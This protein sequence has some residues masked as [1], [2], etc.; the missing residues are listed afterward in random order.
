M[1][2]AI[3]LA[4]AA[5]LMLLACALLWSRWPAWL[6]GVLVIGVTLLYFVGNAAIHGIWG[7]PSTDALPERFLMLSA[8]VEEPTSRGPGAMYLWVS[9]LHEG[10][11][12]LEPRA[13]RLPYSKELH[14]QVNEGLKRGRDGVNQMGTAEVRPGK[15]GLGLP[16]LKPGNDE[17]EVKVR[18]LPAPQLPEK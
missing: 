1:S 5:L 11:P 2:L 7:V 15:A 6:K 4:F 8:V 18:D 12:T 13:F 10:K 3:I 14:T 16:G 9:E 17:Q